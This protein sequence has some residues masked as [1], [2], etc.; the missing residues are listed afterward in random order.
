M[1]ETESSSHSPP[2][3]ASAVF[4]VDFPIAF[5]YLKAHQSHD[6]VL[7][8]IIQ[9]LL[10]GEKV[11]NYLLKQG[12]LYCISSF[13]KK[14][15]IVLPALLIPMVFKY[16][17]ESTYGVHL[18]IFK[19][20]NKV[21]SVFIWHGMDA[22]IGARI[23]ACQ[24]CALSKTA[25]N[26]KVGLLASEVPSSPME[27][28]YVDFVGKLPRSKAGNAYAFVV[29]DGFSKFSWIFPL[30]EATTARTVGVFQSIFAFIGPPQ[31]I[32]SD[33]ARQFTS[34]HFKNLFWLRCKA[35]DHL[36]LLP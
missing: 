29:V 26:T 23:R 25:L 27:R 19:T 1:F 30:R 33:N 8:P 28:I 24:I 36:S 11:G 4:F 14:A 32:V 21:R 15:K 22:D 18:G 34:R 5:A 12:L 13:D 2:I 6:S 20:L 9:R 31:Y 3:S 10:S 16:Y 17:H 35:R 7:D